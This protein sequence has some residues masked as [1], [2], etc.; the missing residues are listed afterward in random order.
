M[1]KR[2]SVEMVFVGIHFIP[3]VYLKGGGAL[4]KMLHSFEFSSSRNS[5]YGLESLLFYFCYVV[6]KKKIW[7]ADIYLPS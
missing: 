5:I 6:K 1:S 7:P 4:K 2:L 3:A